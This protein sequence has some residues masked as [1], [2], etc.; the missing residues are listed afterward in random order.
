MGNRRCA[1]C[2]A[3]RDLVKTRNEHGSL[4]LCFSCTSLPCVVCG[5]TIQP[6]DD[7]ARFMDVEFS[8]LGANGKRQTVVCRRRV[9]SGLDERHRL[10]YADP[11]GFLCRIREANERR[12]AE[13]KAVPPAKQVGKPITPPRRRPKAV[14]DQ[15]VE[16]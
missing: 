10:F 5:M 4:A 2:G 16:L 9:H 15:T 11:A 6:S 7:R 14:S 1:A 3:E 12:K 13:G 8:F